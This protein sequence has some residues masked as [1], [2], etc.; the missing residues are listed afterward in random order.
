VRRL[1]S[2]WTFSDSVQSLEDE[3]R[4][5]AQCGDGVFVFVATG[6]KTCAGHG[7]VAK[8]LKAERR[9][10]ANREQSRESIGCCGP[11]TRLLI[12]RRD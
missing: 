7:G 1:V 6:S 5:V 8:W 11:T 4:A 2:A 3:F 10:L 12:L 9:T